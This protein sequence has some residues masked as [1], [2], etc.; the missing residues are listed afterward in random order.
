MK[1][2]WA[3][4][5]A[6]NKE[7]IR[8]KSALT[9]S[10]VF[11]IVLVIGIGMAFTGNQPIFKVAYMG[12]TTQLSQQASL[13]KA[14]PEIDFI[15]VSNWPKAKIRLEQHEYDLLLDLRQGNAD[16]WINEASDKSKFLDALMKSSPLKRQGLSSK[17][18]RYVDWI[19]PGILAINMMYGALYGV[20]YV[21]VRYRKNGYLKRLQAT[22][23][24]AFEFLTSQMLSRLVISQCVMLVIFA[25]CFAILQPVIYGS[26][27]LLLALS[28]LGAFS[29]CSLGL[30][31][32]TRVASEEFSRG[33]LE[34]ASWPMLLLSQAW[35]SLDSAHPSLQAISK[36]L[37]LTYLIHGW[38]EVMYYG[39]TL[40]EV[41]GD[42][43]FLGG[44][45]F[46]TLLVAGK[47]FKWHLNR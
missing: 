20:G 46:I 13:L 9:W 30:L 23:L 40:K 47:L 25:L 10:F 27:W 32:C 44:F 35:F 14:Y 42:L 36:L 33:L 38:R 3:L 39:A 4:F 2:I 11:P 29:L 34:M 45:G 15:Q 24:T 41:W 6:R 43:L 8:D 12:E 22:P 16:Y 17:N 19:L 21:I 26:L 28:I 37:P 5:W 1:R 18:L 31:L 7:F